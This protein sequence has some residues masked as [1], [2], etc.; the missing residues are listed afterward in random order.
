MKKWLQNHFLPMWAKETVLLDNR[1]LMQENAKLQAKVDALE[2]YVMGLK[3]GLRTRR[4][5]GNENRGERV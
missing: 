5:A 2:A 1:R 4:R 3:T